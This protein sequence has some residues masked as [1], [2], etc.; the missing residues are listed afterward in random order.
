MAQ[1]CP[2]SMLGDPKFFAVCHRGG[3]SAGLWSA[4]TGT[5]PWRPCTSSSAPSPPASM[6]L[7]V[8]WAGQGRNAAGDWAGWILVATTKAKSY[9]PI[10]C[11]FERVCTAV[12]TLPWLC[13]GGQSFQMVWDDI[14]CSEFHRVGWMES[15]REQVATL[16][17]S[18]MFLYLLL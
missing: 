17:A 10:Q 3:L 18:K 9:I 2:Y 11:S 15:H 1:S 13:G 7:L 5:R 8:V 6:C 12:Q 14:H 4:S 16:E